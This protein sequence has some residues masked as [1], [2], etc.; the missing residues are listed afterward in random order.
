MRDIRS[1][2][3]VGGRSAFP[4]E[5]YGTHLEY[6]V[7]FFFP[8]VV[9]HPFFPLSSRGQERPRLDHRLH[10]VTG[11]RGRCKRNYAAECLLVQSIFFYTKSNEHH[12]GT[13][14]VCYFL[15]CQWV[16]AH[17]FGEKC[18]ASIIGCTNCNISWIK[19]SSF[20]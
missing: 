11:N 16:C 9:S 5:R 15:E 10:Y 3:P 7:T 8:L 2:L 18:S 17:P 20:I 4:R 19:I 13:C 14:A 6:I 1:C 12:R